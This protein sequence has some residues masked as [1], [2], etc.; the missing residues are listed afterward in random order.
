MR[1]Q[2]KLSAATALL[3]AVCAA[4]LALTITAGCDRGE[5]AAPPGGAPPPPTDSI[6]D[7][8]ARMLEEGRRTF[9]FDTF[10]NEP[11]WTDQL[12]LHRAIAGAAHGGVGPGLSPRAA[13][14]LGLKV[15]SDALPPDLVDAL[16]KGKVHLDDPAVTL[17]L[18]QRDAVVGVKATPGG[19]AAQ[20][21]NAIG[22]TC[23][24]CHS[25]VDD[26]VGPGI[27]KRLDGF[28]NRD[29]DVGGVVA[30]A[31]DLSFYTRLL[32]VDEA[33][34][35]RVL[36]S[37]GP[38]KFDP[39]LILDGKAF[40]P[41]GRPAAVLIPPAYGLAGVNLATWIGWGTATH[42]NAFV[43]NL[44][45][46][47]QGTFFDSRLDDARR[48]PIAAR[49]RFGHV[50]SAPDRITPK[51]AA[52]HFYQLA[53]PA[54]APPAGSFDPAAAARGQAL[55]GGQARCATCHVPPLFTEPGYNMHR[56]EE[57]G[58]DDFQ[59]NRGPDGRYRT[60]P[61]KG[62]HAHRK[63]GFYHDGRF[64]TLADVIDHYDRHLSLGLSAAQKGD[65]AEYLKSL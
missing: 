28:A 36:A 64:A 58:V 38:G 49:E 23:A 25:S 59:A 27:G 56:P 30:L 2:H 42:W 13:L 21:L 9:R 51:L 65:L 16:Q 34:V 63:G 52:L 5:P 45:M 26:S 41:D 29:L 17:D 53:I 61:L 55:F 50:R 39:E 33:T 32:G 1:S 54:P 20:A 40:R 18:L 43:A 24:L 62:L 35:R 4:A 47:G 10:G 57:I 12:G 31:P 60:A 11:Y 44:E 8:A 6:A 48:F 7:H 3:S 14:A 19:Q 37:W 15:D 46:H 22:V